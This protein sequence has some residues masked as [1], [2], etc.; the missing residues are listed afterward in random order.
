MTLTPPHRVLS[1]TNVRR[2]FIPTKFWQI[3][4]LSPAIIMGGKKPRICF[5]NN[6]F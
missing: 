3:F 6:L 5:A 1:P 4:K 2:S